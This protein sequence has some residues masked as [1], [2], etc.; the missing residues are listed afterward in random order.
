MSEMV[1]SSLVRELREVTEVKVVCLVMKS[2]VEEGPPEVVPPKRYE[3]WCILA[4]CDDTFR[5]LMFTILFLEVGIF[6]SM[7]AAILKEL[8]IGFTLPPLSCRSK[9]RFACGIDFVLLILVFKIVDLLR[10]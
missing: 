3:F 6:G 8:G 1:R 4:G 2:D 9:G 5:I 10:V 7:T